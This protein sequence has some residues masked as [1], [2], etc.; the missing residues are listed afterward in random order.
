VWI[1]NRWYLSRFYISIKLGHKHV[2]CILQRELLNCKQTF[3]AV[4]LLQ[5]KVK[6][7]TECEGIVI[8]FKHPEDGVNNHRKA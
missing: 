1:T 5:F 4:S 6:I 7:I 8:G 3:G 2:F